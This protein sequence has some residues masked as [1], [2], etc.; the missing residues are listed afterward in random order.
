MKRSC[1]TSLKTAARPSAALVPALFSCLA[2]SGALFF[3]ACN[4]DS[5]T[6][7]AP[8]KETFESTAEP[9]SS[10]VE[11]T[12]TG[13]ASATYD[14]ATKKLSYTFQWSGLTGT[15]GGFHIHKGDGSIIIHFEEGDFPTD[16]SGTFSGSATLTDDAWIQ[17]LEAGKLYGQIHTAKY[18]GGEIIFPL[19]KKSATGGTTTPPP[20]NGGGGGYSY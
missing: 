12:A 13:T 2:L 9:S 7:P 3:S 14:P 8:S 16:A 11:T 1:I 19:K 6:P 5:D 20:D 18:P 15:I 17:D 4:K 10:S